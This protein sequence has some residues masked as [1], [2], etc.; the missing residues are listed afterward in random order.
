[1]LE[2]ENLLCWNKRQQGNRGETAGERISIRELKVKTPLQ[3]K[4][5]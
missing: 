1:M 3:K 5:K 4:S 2:T